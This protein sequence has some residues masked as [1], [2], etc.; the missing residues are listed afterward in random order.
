MWDLIVSVPDHCLSFYF[1][2]TGVSKILGSGISIPLTKQQE[3]INRIG[4]Y[5]INAQINQMLKTN[6]IKL[7]KR[8]SQDGGFLPLLLG[9][10]GS[11][12]APVL[13]SVFGK[14]LQVDA[15]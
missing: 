12:A 6:K 13:G 8:H 10:F 2:S 1:A 7:T 15:K 14:G 9:A 3:I 11:L 5:L 4:P